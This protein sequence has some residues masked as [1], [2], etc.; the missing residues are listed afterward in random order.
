[1]KKVLIF[2]DTHGDINRCID[3]IQSSDAV[4]A[5]IHAGDCTADAE[6]L[7][8]AYPH[9][10][11]YYVKGNND[12]FSSAPSS[13]TAIVNGARIFITHGHE[14]RVKY[15]LDYRTLKTKA[16]AARADVVVFGHT[17]MSYISYDYGITAVNPGSIRFDGTYATME[18][19]DG[20][21]D[22]KIKE[23]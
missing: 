15:E 20:K 3:I 22:V 12:F 23:Y 21:I 6:D 19:E 5:I 16:R 4:D 7:S 2:S 10:P 17:H 11:V 13:M 14:E 1:M 18:I 8:Y 9:I